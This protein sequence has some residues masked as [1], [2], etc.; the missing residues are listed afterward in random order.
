MHEIRDDATGAIR[1]RDRTEFQK[2]ASKNLVWDIRGY[3]FSKIYC[4]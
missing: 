3:H 2:I 4:C 1:L